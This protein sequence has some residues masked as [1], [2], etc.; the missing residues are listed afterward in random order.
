MEMADRVLR[1]SGVTPA[2][3]IHSG[4]KPARPMA[5]GNVFDRTLGLTRGLALRMTSKPQS[6]LRAA[7]AISRGSVNELLQY[8]PARVA[9]GGDGAQNPF[10]ASPA[11]AMCDF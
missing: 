11:G 1:T 3:N 2:A 5:N 4:A 6:L 8:Q 7:A 10:S 9:A